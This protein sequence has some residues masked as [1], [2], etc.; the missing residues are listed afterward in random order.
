MAHDRRR[1]QRDVELLA[2]E[3]RERL[4]VRAR[5]RIADPR[6]NLTLSPQQSGAVIANL[7]LTLAIKMAVVVVTVAPIALVYPFVQRHFTRGV[8]L[9]AV[10]G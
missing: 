1:E 9:G 2:R 8:I 6:H 7:P 4:F 5:G 3:L 10:K